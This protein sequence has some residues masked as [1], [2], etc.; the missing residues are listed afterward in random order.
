MFSNI[1]KNISMV[2]YKVLHE[3]QN[4]SSIKELWLTYTASFYVLVLIKAQ[5]IPTSI[6]GTVTCG[7]YLL[8][9]HRELSVAT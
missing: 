2:F 6:L 8:G 5:S 7:A 9:S 1:S 4:L 3:N